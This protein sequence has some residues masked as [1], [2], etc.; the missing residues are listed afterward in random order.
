MLR[1]VEA[2]PVATV[3]IATRDRASRLNRCLQSLNEDRSQTSC[4][5]LIVDNGSTDNTSQVVSAAAE[6]SS[7][8]MRLLQEPIAGVS[9]A[10]N[11]AIRA[12]RGDYL[13]FTDDDVVI[14]DGW[15]DAL[16]GAFEPGVVAVGGRVCPQ[17]PQGRPAWLGDYPNPVTLNDE[18]PVPFEM[19]PDL[20]PVGA[21]M[22]TRR[23]ALESMAAPF[24]TLLGHGRAL[25]IGSEDT[26]LL[27]RLAMTGRI[28]Y[29]PTAVVDHPI[30]D[31]V[32]LSFEG[33]QRRYFQT[34]IGYERCRRLLEGTAPGHV[35][36]L[37][38]LAR[39]TRYAVI[40]H[41]RCTRPA[42]REP[43]LAR[44]ELVALLTL[45][46]HLEMVSSDLAMWCARRF[47]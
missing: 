28:V 14:H 15:I 34:G 36:R 20:L 27:G 11:S 38:L 47:Q 31:P 23:D 1:R 32:R 3:I 19:N 40:A 21:N 33:A 26:Y 43:D 12:A 16:V 5:V 17:F 24:N 9:Y 6:S 41:R 39:A 8:P 45:G 44:E 4:E 46:K 37:E 10:R 35:R 13:L 42:V 25:S 22:A 29:T 18:G 30:D 7:R 2:C